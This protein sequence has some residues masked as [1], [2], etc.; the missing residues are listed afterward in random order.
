MRLLVTVVAGVLA[1]T[2][3]APAY[4]APGTEPDRDTGRACQEDVKYLVRAHRGNLAELDAGKAALDVPASRQVH[5]LAVRL[6]VDHTRFDMKVADTA[7]WHEVALPPK[8]TRQQREDL[9]AVV[10]QTDRAF[11]LAWLRLQEKAHTQTLDYID[12]ELDGGCADDVVDLAD[13]A[14]P[15]VEMHLAMTKKALADLHE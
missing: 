7:D 2:T 6:V 10:E 11:D 15:T 12:R 4:A 5:R 1:A 14:R 8:P 13:A 3:A 9:A